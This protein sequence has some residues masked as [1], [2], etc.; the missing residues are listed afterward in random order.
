[1]FDRFDICDAYYVLEIDYN[2][3]G[4]LHE[5]KSN[6]RRGIKHGY[7]GE[8][9]DVQLNRMGYK[10]SSNLSYETLSDNAKD[11]YDQKCIEYGFGYRGIK[12]IKDIEALPDAILVD[13]DYDVLHILAMIGMLYSVDGNGTTELETWEEFY[14]QDYFGLFVLLD[15]S[16]AMVAVWGYEGSVPYTYKS[17]DLLW[18]DGKLMS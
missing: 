11:I 17:L 18:Y 8:S 15:E 9:T 12:T 10:P 1:M 14:K 7:I 6:V 2:V 5:R 4:W 16:G 3:G 13:R